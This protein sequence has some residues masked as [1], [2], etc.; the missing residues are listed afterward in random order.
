M[1]KYSKPIVLM[2]E[3][4]AEGVYAASGTDCYSVTYQIH[5]TPENGRVDYRIQVDA[6]HSADHHGTHQTLYITFNQPVTY[7]GGTTT[8]IAVSKEYHQN[9][10]DNIGFGDLIVTSDAGL[11]IQSAYVVCDRTCEHN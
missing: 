10:T 7:G 2:N 5:Q 4:L 3:E 6:H 11:S 9:G 8:T 1:N